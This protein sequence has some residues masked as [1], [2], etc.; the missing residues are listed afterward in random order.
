M[1]KKPT[2]PIDRLLASHHKRFKFLGGFDYPLYV[3]LAYKRDLA[4]AAA[5]TDEQVLA[6]VRTYEIA[7]NT[8]LRD[9]AA[10]GVEER[11]GDLPIWPR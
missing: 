2:K 9:W 5:A 7:N 6:K 10:I 8:A 11:A 4:A 3:T 1:M